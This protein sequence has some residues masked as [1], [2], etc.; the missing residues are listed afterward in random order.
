MRENVI[1]EQ[2]FNEFWNHDSRCYLAIEIELGNNKS[3][4][5]SSK[6]ILG[7]LINASVTGSIGIVITDCNKRK[8][9]R[10]YNYLLRLRYLG[11]LQ[12]NTL[13]NLIIIDKDAFISIL[14]ELKNG[15]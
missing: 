11:L 6:H 7:S 2:E 12:L 9:E 14:L 3:T 5:N 8:V 13:G 4:S 10:L 15:N 1:D